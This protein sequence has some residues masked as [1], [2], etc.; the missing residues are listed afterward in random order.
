[1]RKWARDSDRHGIPIGFYR[2]KRWVGDADGGGA[3][4]AYAERTTDDEGVRVVDGPS[5]AVRPD[6]P[7]TIDRI[8][9]ANPTTPLYLVDDNGITFLLSESGVQLT[10]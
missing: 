3:G 5:L 9:V 4:V 1:M 2:T 7:R 10:P 8:T 6:W